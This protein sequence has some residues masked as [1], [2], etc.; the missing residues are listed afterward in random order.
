MQE[1]A[2]VPCEDEEANG[3]RGEEERRRRR[4]NSWPSEERRRR[5]SWLRGGRK[6]CS[7]ETRWRVGTGKRVPEDRIERSAECNNKEHSS[8]CLQCM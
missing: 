7:W 8:C 5:R 2:L 1:L 3:K 6:G 4:R